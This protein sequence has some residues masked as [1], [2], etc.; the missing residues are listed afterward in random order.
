MG[1][2]TG[3]EILDVVWDVINKEIKEE[4]KVKIAKKLI[5]VF[6]SYDC[7]T[8]QETEP[9]QYLLENVKK[10]FLRKIG[11]ENDRKERLG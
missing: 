5:K 10:V 7:D 2:A 11:N 8:T 3:S 6:E 4:S 9:Y 1:W